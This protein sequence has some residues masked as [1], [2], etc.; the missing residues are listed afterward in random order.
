MRSVCFPP[1]PGARGPWPSLTQRARWAGSAIKAGPPKRPFCTARWAAP[2]FRL[3]SS[4]PKAACQLGRLRRAGGDRQPPTWKGEGAFRR[5]ESSRL[6]PT[7][8]VRAL[9]TTNLGCREGVASDCRITPGSGDRCSSIIAHK[10]KRYAACRRRLTVPLSHP[11]CCLLIS[12]WWWP[13]GPAGYMAAITA[14]ERGLN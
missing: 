9:R 13:R 8:V 12:P 5:V 6:S 2:R 7:A 11:P 4:Y 10:L 14:A 3:I 1:S